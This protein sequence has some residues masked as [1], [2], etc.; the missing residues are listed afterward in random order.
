M[1]PRLVHG[2]GEEGKQFYMFTHKIEK[3]LPLFL[4]LIRW[5]DNTGFSTFWLIQ[6]IAEKEKH[7][8]INKRKVPVIRSS[9]A[10]ATQP[11]RDSALRPAMASA[12]A[13]LTLSVA[14]PQNAGLRNLDSSG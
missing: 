1:S 14:E 5:P 6:F 13:P 11:R 2:Q 7:V 10:L 8:A 9:A 12:R 3:N 4:V